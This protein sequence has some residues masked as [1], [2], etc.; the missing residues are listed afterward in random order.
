MDCEVSF[1]YPRLPSKNRPGIPVESRRNSSPD[2][3]GIPGRCRADS[4]GIPLESA[5]III[6]IIIIFLLKKIRLY[7]I[8]CWKKKT[9]KK[10]IQYW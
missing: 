2:F 6:I 9:Y 3:P 10:Q 1:V 8:E 7:N 4:A 5:G